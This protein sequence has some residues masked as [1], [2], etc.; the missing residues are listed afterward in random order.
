[1]ELPGAKMLPYETAHDSLQRFLAAEF[2]KFHDRISIDSWT[3]S[4]K[5]KTSASFDLPSKYIRTV[6]HADI[7]LGIGEGLC[8]CPTLGPLLGIDTEGWDCIVVSH[9][10]SPQDLFFG[11]WLSPSDL[12]DVL[13]LDI[14]REEQHS[15]LS[16]WI[17]MV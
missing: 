14:V 6:F 15:V 4:T 3:V 2:P 8:S 7:D 17:S 10:D 11:A 13:G 12:D 5:E 16:K 1:M 9:P